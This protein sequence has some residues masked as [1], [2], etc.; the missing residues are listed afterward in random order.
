LGFLE[1]FFETRT[2]KGAEKARIFFA[3]MA[4]SLTCLKNVYHISKQK[5]DFEAFFRSCFDNR[6]L[7]VPIGN[8]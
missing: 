5:A 7:I 6:N 3:R 2:G 1:G 8:S 4:Y